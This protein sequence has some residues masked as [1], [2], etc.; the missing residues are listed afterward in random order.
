LKDGFN[1]WNITVYFIFL[2]CRSFGASLVAGEFPD[3]WVFWLAPI[4]GGQVAVFFYEIVIK[5]KPGVWRK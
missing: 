4:L 3:H 5:D 1:S 2:F